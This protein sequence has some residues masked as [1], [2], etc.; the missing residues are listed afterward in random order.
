[1]VTYNLHS[2]DPKE[3]AIPEILKKANYF[4]LIKNLTGF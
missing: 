1:M 3:D 2:K 4:W